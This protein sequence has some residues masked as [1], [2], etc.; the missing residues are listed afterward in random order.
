MARSLLEANDD[1]ILGALA[2]YNWPNGRGKFWTTD[3]EQNYRRGLT[4]AKQILGAT[5]MPV[6]SYDPDAR[7]DAQND[8]WSCSIQS[9]EWLLR[10]V[11]R[12]PSDKWIQDAMLG[13]GL[14]TTDTGLQDGS[15]AALAAWLT[16]EYGAEKGWTAQSAD[17]VTFD[18]VAAGAGVN[19]TLI[20][21]HRWG[22]GGHWSGVRRLNADGS[23]EL[24]NPAIGF[25]GVT[26][27][28]TRTQW[29][30]L[31]PW[32]AV[33]IDRMST[34]PPSPAPDPPLSRDTRVE[35][36]RE[37]LVEALAILDEPVTV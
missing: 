12:D 32:S 10:S 9:T 13:A 23:L 15:G 17:R 26:N 14:V 35:R 34:Q 33:Y 31:G 28:I 27:K 11:G 24:A 3:H 16:R 5:A 7:V 1:E 30:Q 29:D 37:K 19:P 4:E 8:D 6:L 18:D 25:G 21:G 2:R 22:P 20:G 36:A